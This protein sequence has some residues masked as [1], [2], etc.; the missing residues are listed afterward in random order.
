MRQLLL[1]NWHYKLL[2]LLLA[3]AFSLYIY[4][5]GNYQVQATVGVPLAVQNLASNLA[6]AERVASEIRLTV[7][8][9]PQ[10]INS[11]RRSPSRASL[12]LAALSNPGTYVL[13]PELP[14]L[15]NLKLAGFVP[16][17]TVRLERR[18]ERR[19]KVEISHQGSLPSGYVLSQASIRPEEVTVSGPEQTVQRSEHVVG[20]VNL[21]GQISDIVQAVPLVV[22]DKD[23]APLM[24]PSLT[25]IPATVHYT[26]NVKPVADAKV[27][28]V[29]PVL[30]GEPEVGY[31][32]SEVT[33]E[34]SQILL[35]KEFAARHSAGSIPTREIDLTGRTKSFTA[36]VALDYP[37][38]PPAETPKS[39]RVRVALRKVESE[40]TNVVNLTVALQ[41]RNPDYDYLVRP[42]LVA[43]ESEDLV[44]LSSGD[45]AAV[46]AVI[47]VAGFGP[48]VYRVVPTVVLPDSV[49]RL[50]MRPQTVELS[51]QPGAGSGGEGNPAPAE[52]GKGNQG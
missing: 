27:I 9:T 46:R 2:S 36:T 35:E 37:F 29:T 50:R 32:V 48:G 47:D 45:R 21:E 7:S 41:G 18:Q 38:P 30:K 42:S 11:L 34:P 5:F 16:P 22:R 39:V 51:V 33:I 15:P 6:L 52:R 20:V 17:V 44:G 4:Y 12:N 14:E 19:L 8:G 23:Y 10:E 3:M 25:V 40:A 1:N 31:A 43:V 24:L 13:N 49:S 26:A 28:R